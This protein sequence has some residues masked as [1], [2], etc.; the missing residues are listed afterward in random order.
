M[1]SCLPARPARCAGWRCLLPDSAAAGT[2]SALGSLLTL[3]YSALQL[4]N[5]VPADANSL[6]FMRTPQEVVAIVSGFFP[7]GLNGNIK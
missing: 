5:I 1:L 7:L 2:A 4:T 3:H 6:A